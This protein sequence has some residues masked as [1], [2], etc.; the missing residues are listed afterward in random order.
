MVGENEGRISEGTF[1][2]GLDVD[3]LQPNCLTKEVRQLVDLDFGR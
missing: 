3:L 2:G 1:L